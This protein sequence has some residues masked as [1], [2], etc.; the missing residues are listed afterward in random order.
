MS[1]KLPCAYTHK[2]PGYIYMYHRQK[3]SFHST[4]QNT[5]RD[6][7]STL[8]HICASQPTTLH[9]HASCLP[10]YTHTL[11]QGKADIHLLLLQ[12]VGV[13]RF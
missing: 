7:N 3:N 9:S 5:L 2:K 4:F 8:M 13:P 11:T 6:N 12:R 1:E 10:S